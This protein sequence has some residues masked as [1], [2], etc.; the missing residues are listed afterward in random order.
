MPDVKMKVP[1][2][3]PTQ[4]I[5]VGG[6]DNLAN[7][8][9]LE[10]ST[11]L[12][13]VQNRYNDDNIH[14]YVGDILIIL[15]PYVRFP[16]YGAE[17][18]K[19]YSGGQYPKDQVAP[20]PFKV[21]DQAYE[22][23]CKSHK[24]QCFIISGESGAGKTETTKII[25]GQI[26][27][28][29][30]AGKTDLEEKIKNLNPFLEAF[31][32]A[33]TVMNNNS[34]R[35][36]K[37]LELMFDDTD[38]SICGASMSHYLLEKSRVT[39]RNDKEQNFHIF[40]QV[41]AGLAASNRLGDYYLSVPS[42]NNYLNNPPGP[43]DSK[44]L[45]GT[46]ET[47]GDGLASEWQEVITGMAFIGVEG[48]PMESLTKILAAILVAGDVKFKEG[49]AD[50]SQVATQ[51]V[52]SKTSKLLGI[53]EAALSKALCVTTLKVRNET[54]DKF[55]NVEEAA[56][57][58]DAMAKM[59]FNK[60]FVWV[61]ELCNE[62]LVD[63]SASSKE[64]CTIAVLDI[65]GFEVFK[66]NSLEQMCIDLT[67]EQLQGFFNQHIFV[68]EQEEYKAEGIPV[69]EIKFEDNQPTLDL[70]LKPKGQGIF[71][72]LDE[73]TKLGRGS[74][75]SFTQKC[76][77]SFKAHASKAFKGPR[78]ERDL[79]FEITHYAGKVTY[80]TEFF[81]DKNK[82]K[83][84][85][86]ITQVLQGSSDDL[87]AKLF[88]PSRPSNATVSDGKKA[89][90]LV[91][92]FSASLKDLMTRM[93]KCQPHFIRC[94]KTNGEKKPHTWDDELV[95]RQL[96]Y[97]GV[98]ETIRIRKLGYSFRMEFGDFVK[99]YNNIAYHYNE[100]PP[101]TQETAEK[102][103]AFLK[104]ETKGQEINFDQTA[105][106]SSKVFMKYFHQDLL[107]S[108]ASEHSKAVSFLQ[109]VVRGH[110]ARQQYLVVRTEAR[111]Q[112][113]FIEDLMTSCETNGEGWWNRAK[114]L[115]REDEV[116]TADRAG[117]LEK[118]K[119]QAMVAEAETLEKEKKAKETLAKVADEP[120]FLKT[121]PAGGYFVW[122]RNE[123]V[124]LKKG[125]LERPWRKKVDPGT[126]R[127][128]FKNTETR[129]TTWI[130][131]RTFD[132]EDRP[133]NP[134]QCVGDQLP[135]GWDKAETD[136][137]TVFYIDHVTNTHHRHHPK[138]EVANKIQQRA[139]LEVELKA[140][141]DNKLDLINDLKKKEELLTTQIEQE[142][143]PNAKE[144]LQKRLDATAKTIADNTK[145][146]DMLRS[147]VDNL[148]HMIN[149]MQSTKT[150]DV[151]IAD[152]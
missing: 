46:L 11:L 124:T 135:F 19:W 9:Q 91:S 143:D 64:T 117:W 111:Q 66:K 119:M 142:V 84:S 144:K 114:K 83:L 62:I 32:N 38:G 27:H 133:H 120:T 20:H 80:A 55:L 40:Y 58:R 125:A 31:G 28:L 147:K 53:D 76:T 37:Y 74:D 52:V 129:T 45:D 139:A 93:G 57:N 12:K 99:S 82:D 71:S 90:T 34:S 59:I 33:K 8:E 122:M 22:N 30:R 132:F 72:I 16:L 15:N 39:V 50:Q 14:T 121:K 75:L 2:T 148:N 116:A 86:D 1:F 103:M 78:S 145:K 152:K 104:N 5:N 94:L 18:R 79:A 149:Q 98:L 108:I 24:A 60:I 136:G 85:D 23:M 17:L 67:N 137:G 102:I 10:I 140:E 77:N 88:D 7:L 65:F 105:V 73:E 123:H 128:Y 141:M 106:G 25:V 126:G 35:F 13:A 51:D 87:L 130:D 118:V 48:A 29:C 6:P 63:P 96:R 68:A 44:V 41:Y 97:A 54:Q 113:R 43:A 151:L 36:G 146:L 61:F 109:K 138:E 49:A 150:R 95:T 42:K 107:N 100:D 70:F 69:D 115:V 101:K 131:P 89:P 112:K 4:Y 47:C 92:I 81:R 56:S 21:A 127:V 3:D 26:M 110:V 134:T